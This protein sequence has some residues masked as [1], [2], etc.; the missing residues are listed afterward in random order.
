MDASTADSPRFFQSQQDLVKSI[1][2]SLGNSA[3]KFRAS[4]V[5][6]SSSATVLADLNSY[7]TPQRFEEVVDRATYLRGVGCFVFQWL[8]FNINWFSK[9]TKRMQHFWS[10][11]EKETV[12]C[13]YTLFQNGRHF[14]ILLF[15]CK[16][17]LVASFLNSKL[18]RIFYLE[19]GNKG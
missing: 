6:Y 13:K 18:K 4:L 14:T 3:D 12:R 10:G 19:R 5:V 2:R 11:A 17:A 15:A 8:D 9:T 7:T 1:M 16:L